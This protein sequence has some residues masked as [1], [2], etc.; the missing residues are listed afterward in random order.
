MTGI[1]LRMM[2]ISAKFLAM[3]LLI[4]LAACK[5]PAS[6]AVTDIKVEFREDGLSLSSRRIIA[7]EQ[8]TVTVVKATEISHHLTLLAAPLK[9][10]QESPEPT[11][12]LFQMAI[13]PGST[14]EK[15]FRAPQAPGEYNLMCASPGHSEKG[16]STIL[17]VVHPD[18]AR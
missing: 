3:A 2:K 8:I 15:S 12:I 4:L 10:G 13:L 18:Y 14:M 6:Q 16:E 5:P 7:G 1:D 9:K 11:N 17:V